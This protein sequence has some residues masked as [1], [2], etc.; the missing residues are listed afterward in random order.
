MA[1]RNSCWIPLK[2]LMI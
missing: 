1:M 2:S